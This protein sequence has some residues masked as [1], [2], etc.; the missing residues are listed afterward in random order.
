[1][2]SSNSVEHFVT[3][4]DSKYLLAGLAL[5]SSLQRNAGS[6]HLWILCMDALVEGQLSRLA[7]PHT[8]LIPLRDFETRELQQAKATRSQG[9]YC[10]TVTPFTFQAVFTR[11]PLAERVTYIDADLFFYRSPLGLLEE[12]TRSGKDVL[13]TEHAYAPEYDLAWKAGRFCVQ[14]LTCRDTVGADKVIAW[15]QARCLEWCYARL[16]DGKYGDQKYLDWWP[17]LFPKEVHILA[18][19]HETLAPWNADMFLS[20]SGFRLPIFFH[21]HSF[22]I[23]DDSRAILYNGYRIGPEAQKLYQEY[24]ESLKLG[25]ALLRENRIPVATP[26]GNSWRMRLKARKNALLGRYREAL[27][28]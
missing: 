11:E 8:T 5:H 27:L 3:L 25:L 16:E 9:E 22:R 23:I 19:T 18:Q 26:P 13:I 17:R 12:F 2:H 28:A 1:M 14:F 15:W 24:L 21:F 4:F 20:R 10:W 6:Y 7:L